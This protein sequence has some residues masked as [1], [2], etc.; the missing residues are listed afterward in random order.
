MAGER[1][2]GRSPE[3]PYAPLAIVAATVALM[4]AV[5]TRTLDLHVV[6]GPWF[7][8]HWIS[9][10]GAVFI[11]LFTPV[12]YVLKRKRREHYSGLLRV[13]V[14]GGLLSVT[15]VSMH[16]IQHVTRPPEFAPRLGTGVVLY[17]AMALL[18]ATGLLIRQ[19]WL[20]GGMREW[21][22]LHAGAAVTFYLTIG[23]HAAKG[24]GW[25]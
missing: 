24:L 13:H 6:F 8:H 3:S 11:T 1:P 12:Y 18:V 9:W 5:G 10:A 17:A 4:F 16:F 20:S 15:L 25:L 7:A 2:A 23:M 19:R 14:F 22:M 21:R